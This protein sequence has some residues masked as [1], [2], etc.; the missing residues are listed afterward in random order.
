MLLGISCLRLISYLGLLV[1]LGLL[2]VDLGDLT[3]E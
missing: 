3:S 2:L 1:L